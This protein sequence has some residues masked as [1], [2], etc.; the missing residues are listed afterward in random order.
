[1]SEQGKLE[2]ESRRI[3]IEDMKGIRVADLSAVKSEL[4]D[5]FERIYTTGEPFWSNSLNNHYFKNNNSSAS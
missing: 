5:V 4:K 2:R 3:K 1:M